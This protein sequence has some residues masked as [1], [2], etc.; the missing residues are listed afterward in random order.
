MTR[1]VS[2]KFNFHTERAGSTQVT[3]SNSTLCKW[4]SLLR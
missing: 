3:I 1:K 4:A 2:F